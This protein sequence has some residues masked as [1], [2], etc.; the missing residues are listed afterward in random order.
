MNNSDTFQ[1]VV[2]AFRRCLWFFLL[3]LWWCRSHLHTAAVA[4]CWRLLS[5]LF[6]WIAFPSPHHPFMSAVVTPARLLLSWKKLF[7]IL[8]WDPRKCKGPRISFFKKKKKGQCV[9]RDRENIISILIF[10]NNVK[11]KQNLI[12]TKM[13]KRWNLMWLSKH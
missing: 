3:K 2:L 10:D 13:N 1:N 11:H 4:W 9:W 8:C 5:L 6:S 7:S 12:G